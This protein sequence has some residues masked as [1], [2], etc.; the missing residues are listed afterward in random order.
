M[1]K[2]DQFSAAES[3]LGY[4]YQTRAALLLALKKTRDNPDASVNIEKFDD[5]SFD[6]SGEPTELIQT[7]HHLKKSGNLSN[8]SPDIWK[9]LRIWMERWQASE[10]SLPGAILSIVTTAS[11]TSSSAAAL[12][13][14]EK[15]SP[16][17]AKAQLE[18][19]ARKSTNKA[20]ADIY[21]QF[22]GLSE[23]ERS[24]LVQS[25]YVFPNSPTIADLGA[26]IENELGLSVRE[27]HKQP[28][29]E[30]LET[31]WFEQV[32]ALLSG[33]RSAPIGCRELQEHVLDLIEQ[34]KRD[35]LPL[36]YVLAE[37]PKDYVGLDDTGTF[38]KQLKLIAASQK[39]GDEGALSRTSLA[40]LSQA[41]IVHTVHGSGWGICF[42][43]QLRV[44]EERM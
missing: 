3:A 13:C 14:L 31:W 44:R 33:K 20:N 39:S 16:S 7:K 6:N 23:D 42:E 10:I 2:R 36:D 21:E 5:I 19:T 28:F 4:L 22:L 12:L 43:E 15:R 18:S 8:A 24:I 34:F 41:G 26:E 1:P 11:T 37:P 30:R 40:R 27:K 38:I 35:A 9:T 25:V 29:R 32:I 17:D